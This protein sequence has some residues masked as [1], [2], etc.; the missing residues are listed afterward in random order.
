MI[1]WISLLLLCACTLSAQTK[2]I[3]IEGG[4]ED[5]VRDLQKVSTKAQHYASHG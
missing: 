3:L 4:D 5:L 2:K 1:R